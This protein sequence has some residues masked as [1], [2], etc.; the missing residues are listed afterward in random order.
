MVNLSTNHVLVQYLLGELPPL[1]RE[2]VERQYFLDPAVWE[3]LTE[4]E[5]EL[6]DDYVYGCLPQR[7]RERFED[8]FMALPQMRERVALTMLLKNSRMTC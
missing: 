5:R 1:E 7:E 8:Y 2:W 4:T 3:L 6:I